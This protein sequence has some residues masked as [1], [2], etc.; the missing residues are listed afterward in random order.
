MHVRQCCPL[1]QTLAVVCMCLSNKCRHAHTALDAIAICLILSVSMQIRAKLQM[2]E[3]SFQ[4]KGNEQEISHTA[5]R[6]S[7]GAFA[8]QSALDKVSLHSQ[9]SFKDLVGTRNA[10][11]VS[12]SIC[13][14][15]R[16]LN[17]AITILLLLNCQHACAHLKL[18]H[19]NHYA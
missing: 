3:Q 2:L 7:V 16:S 6:L 1:S 12:V 18:V 13:K 10:C 4:Y 9:S 11:P 15:Y 14:D 17:M 19:N 5:H 8:L